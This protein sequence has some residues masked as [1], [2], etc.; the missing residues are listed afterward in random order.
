MAIPK[1]ILNIERPKGTIVRHS[2]G[3]YSVVK[4]GSKYVNGKAI[5]YNIAVVGRI[6]NG[7]YVPLKEPKIMKNIEKD[8]TII[9]DYGDVA[10]F[11]SCGINIY[12]Q[13]QKYFDEL[14]AKKLYLIALIRCGYPNATAKDLGFHYKTSFLSELFKNVSFSDSTHHEFFEKVGKNYAKIERFMVDRISQ[15]NKSIQIVDATLKSNNFDDSAFV[16]TIGTE[17]TKDDSDFTLL[18]T[19]DL[20][21]KEPIYSRPYFWN[22][23]DSTIFSD[24]LERIANKNEIIVGDNNQWNSEIIKEIE[25]Q[26]KSGY[27]F[28][29][30]HSSKNT[31]ANNLTD[32]LVPLT[33]KDK[34]ILGKITILKTN[35]ITQLKIW[36]LKQKKENHFIKR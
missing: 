18:Y 36:T 20:E 31:L 17:K 35:I 23:I 33:F 21:T 11:H 6:E 16:N 9:K 1:E 2:F 12:K 24:Y 34:K 10:I 30:K 14:T 28:P 4:R 13:L 32:D 25:K 5:P 15:F 3:V 26:K 22:I 7:Q 29:I 19:Y 8:L 27:L